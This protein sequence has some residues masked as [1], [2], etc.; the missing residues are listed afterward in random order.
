MYLQNVSFSWAKKTCLQLYPIGCYMKPFCWW[1]TPIEKGTCKFKFSTK[2]QNN[3]IGKYM[4][5][6]W[7]EVLC[8]AG[9][10]FLIFLLSEVVSRSS[11][12]LISQK[13]HSYWDE[14]EKY[15]NSPLMMLGQGKS[16]KRLWKLVMYIQGSITS[17]R[18]RQMWTWC[19]SDSET[20]HSVSSAPITFSAAART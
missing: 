19:R 14:V 5:F 18:V 8:L 12:W 2:F 10:V 6:L 4:I 13:G 11:L 17:T 15:Q 20:D 9:V 16:A 3:K 1:I 7:T